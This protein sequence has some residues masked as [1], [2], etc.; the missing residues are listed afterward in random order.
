M[1]R[2]PKLEK[3]T[4]TVLVNATPITVV[5]HPPTGARKTWYAYWNGLVSSKSTGQQKLEDAVIVAESMLHRS[6]SGGPACPPV[7]AD[8]LLSDEEFEAIQKEHY[9]KKQGAD[10]Q[11]RAAKS[12][13]SCLEAIQAFKVISGISPISRATPDDCAAFQR[14][15]L[16]LPKNTLHP[17]PT[18]SKTPPATAPTPC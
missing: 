6:L 13:Q 4:I 17:Y 5:L 2:K 11:A 7:L 16:K 12:L 10:A 1:P 3:K 9:G 18:A 14:K 8:L 15:A